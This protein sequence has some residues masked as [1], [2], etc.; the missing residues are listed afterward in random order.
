MCIRVKTFYLYK[1]EH[2]ISPSITYEIGYT[3][4]D[5]HINIVKKCVTFS[6][7]QETSNPSSQVPCLSV[8]R[9]R[10]GDRPLEEGSTKVRN[11]EGH[12]E[13]TLLKMW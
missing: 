2:S 9:E 1:V 6:T 7:L 8:E 11:E 12:G 13:W 3:L 4:L 5:I 10:S